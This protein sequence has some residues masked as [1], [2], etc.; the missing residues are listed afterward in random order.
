MT[1]ALQT[2]HQTELDVDFD[3][4]LCHNYKYCC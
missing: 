1:E 4:A 2:L 3:F